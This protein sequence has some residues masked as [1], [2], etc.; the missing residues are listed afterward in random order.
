MGVVTVWVACVSCITRV[1]S[2]V[3]TVIEV[4]GSENWGSHRSR[5]VYHR[6][7]VVHGSN[8]QRNFSSS[9]SIEGGL[10]SSLSIGNLSLVSQVSCGHWSRGKFGMISSL[11]LSKSGSKYLFGSLD[12]GGVF[13]GDSGGNSQKGSKNE[14]LHDDGIP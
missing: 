5:G 13:N 9:I 3:V 4:R 1:T 6:H 2:T 14:S 10:E 11:S 8:R 7:N 12:L